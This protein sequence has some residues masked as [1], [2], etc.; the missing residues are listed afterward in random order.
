MNKKKLISL[1]NLNVNNAFD[2]VSHLRFLYNMK[3][4]KIFKQI[5]KINEKLSEKQK[6]NIDYRKTH[7]DKAQN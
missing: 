1:F 2:N 3:K 6:H 5:I 4:R 7:D